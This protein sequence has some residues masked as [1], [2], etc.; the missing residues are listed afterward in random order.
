MVEHMHLRITL[1]GWGLNFESIFAHQ[2]SRMKRL[3]NVLSADST[4]LTIFVL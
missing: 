3:K 1:T 4:D 2:K